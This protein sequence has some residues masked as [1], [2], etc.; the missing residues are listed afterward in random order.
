MEARVPQTHN[1]VHF[2]RR[3]DDRCITISQPMDG[4]GCMF[5]RM[6]FLFCSISVLQRKAQRNFF[7]FTTLHFKLLKTRLQLLPEKNNL[8]I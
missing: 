2:Q 3:N 6:D 8:A 4:R 5:K 7:V 1:K